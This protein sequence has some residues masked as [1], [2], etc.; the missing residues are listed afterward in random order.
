M[1]KE[2]AVRFLISAPPALVNRLDTEAQRRFSSRA[3]VIREAC[4]RLLRQTEPR[5]DAD[6]CGNAA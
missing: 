1:E 4:E 5:R 2:R 3:Q 6:E